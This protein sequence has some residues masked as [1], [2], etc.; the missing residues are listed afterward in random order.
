MK[1]VFGLL[2]FLFLFT[3][4]N[5]SAQKDHFL[6]FQTEGKQS[7]YIKLDNKI[8]SSSASGYL[9]VPK[10]NES[11]YVITFGFP[12]NEWSEQVINYKLNKDA[13]L[14]LKNFGE[15]GWGV[16]NLQSSNVT[17]AGT[18]QDKTIKNEQ[19]IS[20][21]NFSNMLANVVNDST[22]KQKDIVVKEEVKEPPVIAANQEGVST[23]RQNSA[24]HLDTAKNINDVTL[25]NSVIL[26]KLQRKSKDGMEMVYV[27]EYN[28]IKDT[29]RIFFPADKNPERAKTKSSEEVP[30]VNADTFKNNVENNESAK[31]N[32]H[33]EISQVNVD[34]VKKADTNNETVKAKNL[35]EVSPLNA[36]TAK[37]TDKNN[38]TLKTKTSEEVTQV[39]VDTVK[40]TPPV[41]IP[42]APQ[43][44]Q[45]KSDSSP[46][47]VKED[48][49]EF[50]P[51]KS[52][53]INS[54]CR[55][56][57][58]EDDFLKLRKKMATENNDDNMIK[59]AKKV[60]K[61]KC[62]TTQHVKNLGNLFLKDE[63]KYNFFDAAYPYIS[64][65][66]VFY[67]LQNQF[68]DEYY[69]KR[70]KAMIRQ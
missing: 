22:I 30:H 48:K 67:T 50:L 53:V 68:S 2:L 46:V 14:L 6:Y 60:F 51:S 62:F 66:N 27:D 3:S 25:L 19:A 16:V 38:E 29:I 58:T 40:S 21:D 8:F 65:S 43:V 11:N 54:N 44:V 20:N 4:I 41:S 52:G 49:M 45:Q 5:T 61:M 23:I 28:N 55:T 18:S 13:G 31:T 1:S 35:E 64:D 15:K 47:V 56:Y 32:L 69:L 37:N 9:I 39:N 33:E 17:M 26:K 63:G 24:S 57:A 10:L 7:F 34:T 70:F 12:K 36:D 42:E 59:V